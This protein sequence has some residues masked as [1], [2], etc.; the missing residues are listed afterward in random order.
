MTMAEKFK[1][2]LIPILWQANS[3]TEP[4]ADEVYM[5]IEHLANY[6]KLPV[7]WG[8]YRMNANDMDENTRL[9]T[10]FMWFEDRSVLFLQA[11]GE[12]G[13][14][15]YNCMVVPTTT[16]ITMAEDFVLEY[17]S[18]KKPEGSHTALI[19]ELIKKHN[20][21]TSEHIRYDCRYTTNECVRNLNE[22]EDVKL[23][24]FE[25]GSTAFVEDDHEKKSAAHILLC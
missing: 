25:D 15:Q 2:Q 19:Q 4:S 10:F 17:R 22:D 14:L 5:Y 21:H 13:S 18:T 9:V 20:G 11:A 7:D 16:V 23:C 3:D 12:P 6:L 24:V 8:L 1:E